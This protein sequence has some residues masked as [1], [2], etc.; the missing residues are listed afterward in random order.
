M[1]SFSGIYSRLACIAVT[2]IAIL[3]H[4]DNSC[5]VH[6]FV[7]PSSSLTIKQTNLQ[8]HAKASKDDNDDNSIG[9]VTAAIGS[10]ILTLSILLQPILPATAADYASFSDEQ[11]FV[12]EAWRTVD[13]A[14]IDRTF[15]HQDWFKLRQDAIK[16]KYKNMA[17]AQTEVENILG[18]LGDRYTRYLPPAKYDSI[19]NAA[20]GN[21]YG[22][23][24]ELAQDKEG[25]KVIASD[26]EPSGPA[27]KGGLKPNDV[28][29]EV[30][31][32]RFD[33]GKAT[34]GK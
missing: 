6:S 26:V 15:N 31:G 19:V 11:R 13:N 5:L 12:A 22:V 21:V 17:E 25:M 20:T 10:T 28:F 1:K 29:V 8:L 7:L 2:L 23:G 18:S 16:K 4:H 33:D 34:P 27:A 32:E 24:V 9:K 30:D 3:D 14:Y